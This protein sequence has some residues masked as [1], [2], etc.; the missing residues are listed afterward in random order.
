VAASHIR[1]GTFQYAAAGR[2]RELLRRLADYAIAR[3]HPAAREA[4]NPYVVF[5]ES[6]LGAQADLVARWMQAGFVHGVMNTDNMA[7]SG[8]SIDFGPCAFIDAY[9][10]AASFS[11]IDHGGRYAYGNQP[12]IA[13]WNLARLAEAL[14]GLFAAEQDQAIAIAQDS[15]AKFPDRFE[16]TWIAGMRSKLGMAEAAAG[17]R[18]LIDGLLSLMHAQAVDFTS[19]F[20]ALSASLRAGESES[21]GPAR[22]LFSEPAAFDGWWPAWRERVAAGSELG[23]AADRMDRVNP[24]YI[25]RNHLVEEALAS[26]TA[27]ELDDL[28]RLLAAVASPFEERPGLERYAVPAP[29]GSGPYRT[30][31]G[32]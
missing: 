8:E 20:R 6:V 7:V 30:F 4:E 25:P 27:G 10:P 19:C 13:Q 26:A 17:D 31:C 21:P 28:E 16:D 12:A 14:L 15:L 5:F 29:A 3:H 23:S 2:D 24:L 9:D 18:E 11:S 32:T 1:V 22:D